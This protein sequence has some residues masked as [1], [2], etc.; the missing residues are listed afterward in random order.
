LLKMATQA[1]LT[2]KEIN[3]ATGVTGRGKALE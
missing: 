1:G 3:S 2:E